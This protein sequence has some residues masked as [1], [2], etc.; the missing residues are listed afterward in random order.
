MI[1]RNKP[2]DDNHEQ[3]PLI[4]TRKLSEQVL[5]ILDKK[6]LKPDVEKAVYVVLKHLREEGK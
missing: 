6:D 1:K 4:G 5:Q 2:S 3:L